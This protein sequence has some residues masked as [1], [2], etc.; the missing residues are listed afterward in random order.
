MAVERMAS[1]FG[2][3]FSDAVVV[4]GGG[5]WIFVSGQVGADESGRIVEGGFR[6]EADACLE[7]IHRSLENCGATMSHV[8][9]ITGFIA[10]FDQLYADYDAARETAFGATPPASATVEVSKLGLG[11]RIEVEAIAFVPDTEV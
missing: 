9:K 10:D 6:K 7:R 4:S 3:S 5:K 8:V 1:S 11:A 2:S